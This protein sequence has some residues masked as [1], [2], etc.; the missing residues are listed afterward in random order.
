MIAF[1]AAIIAVFIAYFLSGGG[2]YFSQM[3]Q[4]FIA[5]TM[6]LSGRLIL[7]VPTMVLGTGCYLFFYQNNLPQSAYWIMVFV[8]VFIALPYILTILEP[9]IYDHQNVIN[10]YQK[11]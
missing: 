4:F 5:H 10:N 1:T 6:K 11:L 3:R 8:N 9:A 7:T 2:Y